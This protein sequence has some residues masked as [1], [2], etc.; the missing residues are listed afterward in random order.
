MVKLNSMQRNALK[1]LIPLDGTGHLLED[2]ESG[3]FDMR[4]MSYDD[5]VRCAEE[6]ERLGLVSV[7]KHLTSIA[8]SDCTPMR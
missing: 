3:R 1:V 2:L 8:P 4:G 6:L 5:V 7:K